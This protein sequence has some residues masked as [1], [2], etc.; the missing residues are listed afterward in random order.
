MRSLFTLAIVLP[1]SGAMGQTIW[2]NYFNTPADW[3]IE[4]DGV[5]NFD[6]QIGVGLVNTGPLLIDPIQSSTAG[7]GYA[8]LDSD[9]FDNQTTDEEL[10][11]ITT[12]LPIDLSA[13]ANVGLTFQTNY[14]ASSAGRSYV[15]VST[16]G[17]FP[18]LTSTTDISGM[19]NVFEPFVGMPD[20]DYTTNPQLVQLNIS[21]VAS[22]QPT[23]WIRF[24]WTGN[25]GYA[26]FIDDVKLIELPDV[27]PQLEATH[28]S[29]STFVPYVGSTPVAQ[30]GSVVQLGGTVNNEG[31]TDQSNVLINVNVQGADP[32][33]HDVLMTDIAYGESTSLV[34]AY[35]IPTLSAGP[36]E[37]T[38]TASSDQIALDADPDNNVEVRH[39]S[40]TENFY[41]LDGIGVI[42]TGDLQLGSIGTASFPD[43]EDGAKLFSYMQVNT[44]TELT[45]ME[46]LLSAGTQAGGFV[47]FAVH[48]TMD[49]LDGF[50]SGPLVSSILVPLTPEAVAAGRV[51]VAFPEGT[52]L[53]PGG[54]YLAI[55]LY[56]NA[57]ANDIVVKDDLTYPQPITSSLI[58]HPWDGTVYANGNALAVRAQ[59]GGTPPCNA[60]FVASQA[61][62]GNGDPLPFVVNIVN[63]STGTAPDLYWVWDFG[64]GSYST[65][66]FPS[67][68]YLTNGP[69]TLCLSISNANGC[70]DQFCDDIMVDESGLFTRSEGFT[71]H[72]VPATGV[73][74]AER[75]ATEELTIHPNPVIDMLRVTGS[76]G[77]P[78]QIVRITD[79][80]GRTILERRLGNGVI[81]V[82]GLTPGTYVLR[83]DSGL[84]RFVKQ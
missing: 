57:G 56:S 71:I 31:A 19:L 1:L 74:M 60:E 75:A 25:H 80:Q 81:N 42:P 84:A 64:D 12:S 54:Y 21:A 76:S 10:A 58:Y 79:A 37:A 15:V 38:F 39:F 72:V 18:L 7:T 29:N 30:M 44:P 48:D 5:V 4:H 22:G 40:I 43:F 55:S 27:D 11:H 34:E 32:F 20:G 8:M 59:L 2:S 73:G 24:M 83:T 35:T 61:T 63:T 33:V 17:N 82:S 26:W 6:W 36:Y 47:E 3:I 49:V 14:R 68:E 53:P 9:G 51:Q 28:I 78:Q 23:V 52:I 46:A 66:E 70:T 13:S 77:S 16:D 65:D 50:A 45:A 41:A 67:H 62:D 69:Y